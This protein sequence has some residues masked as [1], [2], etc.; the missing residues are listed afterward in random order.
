MRAVHLLVSTGFLVLTLVPLSSEARLDDVRVEADEMSVSAGWDGSK[1][2]NG[3]GLSLN[4]GMSDGLQL[5]VN[6]SDTT[7]KNDLLGERERSS[8]IGVEWWPFSPEVGSRAG[9]GLKV[10]REK[11]DD[12]AGDSSSSELRTLSFYLGWGNSARSF[13]VKIDN[14]YESTDN[15]SDTYWGGSVS[16]G[17]A[18]NN[19]T[20]LEI[21]LGDTEDGESYTEVSVDFTLSSDLDMTLST[22]YEDDTV[23]AG[24]YFRY[25]YTF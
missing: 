23:A 19:T 8:S 5:D 2:S 18:L 4:Y 13:D 11:F 22:T 20:R 12:D 17:F 21:E 25:S 15:E 10:G 6:I 1:N 14:N 7:G 24:L 3:Y 9:F 16:L